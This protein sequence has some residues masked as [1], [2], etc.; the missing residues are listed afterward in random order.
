MDDH[1]EQVAVARLH[2]HPRNART[3]SRKQLR[4]IA[5]SIERFGFLA[6]VLIDKDNVIL[7]GHARVEAAKQ[8]GRESVPCRRISHLSEEDQ[9]AYILADNQ[10]ALK[11]GWDRDILAIELQEFVDLGHDLTVLGFEP[12]EVDTALAA[13][14][15]AK[16]EDDHRD[17]E[18]PAVR[19]QPVTQLGDIWNLGA[20]RIICSDARGSAGY[21]ALMRGEK[22]Q[23]VFTD[24]PYNVPIDGF[25]GG[26]GKIKHSEFAMASGEMSVAA[27][28]TFLKDTLGLAAANSQD[29]AIHYVC[30]D[31][32]HIGELREAGSQIYSEL[33]NL[34]VWVKD[35]G[36]M[37]TFYRSRHELIFAYKVGTAPH[38]NTFELGQFGRHRT[39]V[40]EYAGV[41]SMRSG[42]L[43]ELAMHPTVKPT[44]LVADALK[45]ASH[46]GA[47]VLDPF[48]GSGTTLIA[49]ERTGRRARVIEI[50]PLYVDVAVR[51]WQNLTGKPAILDGSD[52]RF[53]DIEAT[54]LA[55]A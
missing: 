15:E 39:N 44:A 28:T 1:L 6:P 12:A 54:F 53:D 26:K 29:G 8:L 33:K 32:R 49:A 18:T 47:I 16:G 31:W 51:R 19:P 7:A 34:I 4:M 5:R 24:P 11:S 3:H 20:H 40:W 41:N 38:V 13:H 55:P 52:L 14:A 21:E 25:V 43:D 10:L 37:G 48:S 23:L 42:R 27:F 22:A 45:D 50:D 9:R 17:D 2:P 30:M 36:G 46:P 35:N